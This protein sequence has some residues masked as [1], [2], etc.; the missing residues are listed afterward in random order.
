MSENCDV[1][2]IFGIH[3]Q[4]GA[5]RKPNFGWIVCKFYILINI[6]MLSYKNFR[7]ITLIKGTIL[8]KK[9]WFFLQKHDGISKIKG[10]L[11]NK[12]IAKFQQLLDSGGG[13]ALDGGNF[14]PPQNEHLKSPPRLGLIIYFYILEFFIFGQK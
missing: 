13:G 11:G 12:G 4:F 10:G 8:A 6:N 1:I 14:H 5:V 9:H 2:A 3:N 7:T